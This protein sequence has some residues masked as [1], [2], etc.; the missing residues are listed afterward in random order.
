MAKK[1]S[2]TT[3][4]VET[5]TAII[6]VSPTAVTGT[7]QPGEI[8]TLTEFVKGAQNK[9]WTLTEKDGK[10]EVTFTEEY[11]ASLVR[12]CT[13]VGKLFVT[14]EEKQELLNAY[15]LNMLEGFEAFQKANGGKAGLPSFI[16]N[17]LKPAKPVSYGSAG[18]VERNNW[19]RDPLCQGVERFIKRAR[20]AVTAQ[21]EMD[22]LVAAEVKR[23]KAGGKMSEEQ[24]IVEAQKVRTD[25]KAKGNI[26]KKVRLDG[27]RTDNKYFFQAMEKLSAGV[28]PTSIEYLI[29]HVLGKQQKDKPTMLNDSGEDLLKKT[30]EYLVKHDVLDEE[31]LERYQTEGTETE[32]TK[33]S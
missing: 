8:V 23:L 24:A 25:A 17:V 14:L 19:N 5:S 29:L 12:E 20:K 16:N 7:I 27:Q 28:N 2:K 11:R 1:N 22:A 13:A 32:E 9:G 3:A 21:K 33:A 4:S 31:V 6:P 18:S 30:L 15:A 26:V 10:A